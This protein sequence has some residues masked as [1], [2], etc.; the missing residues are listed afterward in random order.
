MFER[1]RH[2][3]VTVVTGNQPLNQENQDE[4]AR[5][6]QACLADGQP[7][8]VFDLGEVPLVD[9]VGLEMLLEVREQYQ[10]R[11]GILK[12]A[13]ANPLCRDA[14]HVTRVDRFFDIYD[15]V[16]DAVGSFLR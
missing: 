8:A 3:A 4:A 10:S 5:Q 2:G 14:L 7:M 13:R 12:L 11:G 16:I 6:L 9:S 1:T 15:N